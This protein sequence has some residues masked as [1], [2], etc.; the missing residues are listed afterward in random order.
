MVEKALE[1]V[2]I[3]KIY[4]YDSVTFKLI[5]AML[6]QLHKLVVFVLRPEKLP[7]INKH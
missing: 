3:K 4:P 6:G 7:G 5:I 2:E 1:E